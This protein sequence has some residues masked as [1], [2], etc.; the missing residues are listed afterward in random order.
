MTK[1]TRDTPE[2]RKC[3]REVRDK[4][5]ELHDQ[6]DP[7]F[8]ELYPLFRLICDPAIDEFDITTET[9]IIRI[10]RKKR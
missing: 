5:T 6:F 3:F 4:L 8:D 10:R 1:T 9:H 2:R 7:S